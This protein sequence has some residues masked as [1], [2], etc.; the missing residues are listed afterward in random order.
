MSSLSCYEHSIYIQKKPSEYVKYSY[1]AYLHR[2]LKL[3]S[4][5]EETADRK[6]PTYTL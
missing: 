5:Y 6:L 3:A 2:F 4:L 1:V